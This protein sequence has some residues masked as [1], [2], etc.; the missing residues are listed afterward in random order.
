VFE[1]MHASNAALNPKFAH[2]LSGTIADERRHVGFG[3]NR[4]GGLVREHPE[5][6]PDIER[7]QKEM[8]YHMLATFADSFRNPNMQE[9][10]NRARAAAGEEAGGGEWQGVKLGELEPG[11]IESLLG[12]TVLAEFK[13]RLERI[14]LDYQTPVRP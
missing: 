3:E 6:K 8:S 4:I 2:T 12:D 13:K 1:M 5:R 14:G 7:M 11:E 9:E 10:M